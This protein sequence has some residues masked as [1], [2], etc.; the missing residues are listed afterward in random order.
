MPGS[1]ASGPGLPIMRPMR[2]PN[3]AAAPV[4]SAALLLAL[5]LFCAFTRWGGSYVTFAAKSWGAW[6]NGRRLPLARRELVIY[7][8]TFPVLL[9]IDEVTPPDAVVLMPP[10]QFVIDRFNRKGEIPL[11]ASPSS[12]YNFIYPRVPVHYGDPSPWKDRITHVLIWEHWGLD[13]VAP[14]EP[15][16]EENRFGLVPWPSGRKAPW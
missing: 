5:T 1:G 9:H 15:P 2:I 7:D 11:L 12:A 14:G 4:R 3:A 10:R 8:K 16:T 6:E 13:L